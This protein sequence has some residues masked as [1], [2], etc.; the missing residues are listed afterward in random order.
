MDKLQQICFDTLTSR[1]VNLVIGYEIGSNKQ[2]RPV[3]ISKPEQCAGLYFVDHCT[4]N[5]AVYL[6]K[7]DVKKAG[8]VAVICTLPAL[9]TI[10]QLE[11]ENQVKEDN[12]VLIF[13]KNKDEIEV[14]SNFK[15]L[16]ETINR[17]QTI[18]DNQT[19]EEIDRILAM[20]LQERY[21]YWN[22]QFSKCIKCYACRAACPLCY[23]TRCTIEINQP[24]WVHVPSSPIGNMEW[25]IMRAMHMAGRCADCDACRKACP[26]DIPL[27]LLTKFLIRDIKENFGETSESPDKKNLLSTYKPDDKENF[28]R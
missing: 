25:H 10:I 28:F 18:I 14:I 22:D 13:P 16:E 21:Q 23:C 4:H 9:R 20:P 24:Q 1:L 17:A 15:T 12:L 26:V 27:N 2:P 6:T 11:N 3:F 19:N 7:P 8:K 5:L